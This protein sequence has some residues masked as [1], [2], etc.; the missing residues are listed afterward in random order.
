MTIVTS[1]APLVVHPSRAAK[2]EA[3]TELKRLESISLSQQADEGRQ[4]IL[5][6]N[7]PTYWTVPVSPS[8]PAFIASTTGRDRRLILRASDGNFAIYEGNGSQWARRALTQRPDF[9]LAVLPRRALT[10]ADPQ[11]VATAKQL[12]AIRK[13]LDL[14]ADSPLPPLHSVAVGRLIERILIE[15]YLPEVVADLHRWV[16]ERADEHAA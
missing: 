16:E 1:S 11:S 15:R 12:A 3:L 4:V 6:A 7:V 10:P 14:S 13:F 9:L 8:L 2:A 5:I